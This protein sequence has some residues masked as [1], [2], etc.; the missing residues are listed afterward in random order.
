MSVLTYRGYHVP[1]EDLAVGECT[2][3]PTRNSAGASWWALWF[4][5]LRETDGQPDCFEVPINP[6][7]SYS[8]A[9]PG[10]KTWGLT[11]STPG[12]WQVSPSINVLNTR[13]LHPGAHP[14][15]PSLWHQTPMIVGVP[16]GEPWIGGAP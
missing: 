5:V 10:G 7:G 2:V 8:E 15:A 14:S 3:R 12:A 13:D 4:C 16:E 6:N 1:V 11:R 9:G